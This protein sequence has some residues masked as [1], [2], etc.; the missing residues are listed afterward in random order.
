MLGQPLT[1][2]RGQ[3][4]VLF[5][6]VRTVALAHETLC[7]TSR[8]IHPPPALFSVLRH[9]HTASYSSNDYFSDTLLDFKDRDHQ[10][11]PDADVEH[12]FGGEIAGRARTGVAVGDSLAGYWSISP[13]PLLRLRSSLHET[14]AQRFPIARERASMSEVRA[15]A[16]QLVQ[17]HAVM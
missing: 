13:S 11:A 17:D 4:K 8:P 7:T 1:Q 3:Q 2:A 5:R 9:S 12:Q 6:K 16:D 15:Y 10:V 14:R